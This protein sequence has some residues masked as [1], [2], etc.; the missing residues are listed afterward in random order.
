MEVFADNHIDD[1]H[2]FFVV[3][4]PPA[5]RGI[6]STWQGAAYA[7]EN[8]SVSPLPMNK[9]DLIRSQIGIDWSKEIVPNAE[10]TDLDK[11]A[12]NYARD[13]FTKKKKLIKTSLKGIMLPTA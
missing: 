9:L 2:R 3:E 13:M 8:E 12:I 6:P 10:I 11:D 5:Y 4:I 7:R 1:I